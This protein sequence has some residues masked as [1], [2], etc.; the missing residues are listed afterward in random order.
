MNFLSL[1]SPYILLVLT[2][3]FLM[4]SVQLFLL[5][6]R[7][8]KF[9]HGKEASNFE[10]IVLRLVEH[11]EEL[12]AHDKSL[13]RELQDIDKRV[14]TSLR[15]ASFLR[16]KAMENTS[17]NQSFSLALM[18]EQGDGFVLSSLHLRDRISIYGK[19]VSNWKSEVELSEEEQA[20]IEE[21]KKANKVS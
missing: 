18:S 10:D 19:K 13:A 16:F 5:K 9:M 2:F 1:Y 20:V 3:I 15:N 14:S 12:K 21:T 6:K 17:S 8:S 11:V 4:Q 7:L